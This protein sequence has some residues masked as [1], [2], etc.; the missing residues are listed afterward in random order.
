MR[1][2]TSPAAGRFIVNAPKQHNTR[3]ENEAI[4]AGKTP[5]G[6]EEEPAK[7]AQE[8]KQARWTKKKDQSF[9][10]YKNQVSTWFITCA[11]SFGWS[12][13]RRPV[14]LSI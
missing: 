1:R 11:A 13:R 12:G 6:W 9:Y 5:E 14:E 3:K 2:G 8:D 10:G 4:K 7:N